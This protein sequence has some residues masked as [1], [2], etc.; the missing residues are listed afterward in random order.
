MGER[1]EQ[2][3]SAQWMQRGFMARIYKTQ[4]YFLSHMSSG[5]CHLLSLAS[6]FHAH[7]SLL[8]CDS[9]AGLCDVHFSFASHAMLGF[10]NRGRRRALKGWWRKKSSFVQSESQHILAQLA[11]KATPH[12]WGGQFPGFQNSLQPVSS[13]CGQGVAPSCHRG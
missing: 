6:K 3:S 8:L 12:R 10:A 11:P 9:G 5:M 13:S 7:P 2:T 4:K 1:L